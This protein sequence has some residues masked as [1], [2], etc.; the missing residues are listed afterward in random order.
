MKRCV[1]SE[2]YTYSR[3]CI[4][5]IVQLLDNLYVYII[6]IAYRIRVILR[7]EVVFLSDLS[8]HFGVEKQ[9]YYYGRSDGIVGKIL[10]LEND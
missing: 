4:V 1:K 9:I 7:D 6:H 3:N 10:Y 2:R 5:Y 8:M